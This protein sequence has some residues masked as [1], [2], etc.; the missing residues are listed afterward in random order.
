M[1]GERL[2]YS[3]TETSAVLGV[4][5]PTVYKLLKR[6]DFPSFKIGTRTLVP[7]EGLRE[8]LKKQTELEE[9]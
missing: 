8:W 1:N 4:S 5:K 2:A 3:P 9:R 7:A 6:A